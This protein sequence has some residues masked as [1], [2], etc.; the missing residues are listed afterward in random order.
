MLLAPSQSS[1]QGKDAAAM[2]RLGVPGRAS[3][4]AWRVSPVQPD[5]GVFLVTAVHCNHRAPLVRLD[6]Q[7]KPISYLSP[8][9]IAQ[10]QDV[11]LLRYRS[12]TGPGYYTISD[13]LPEYGELIVGVG[14]AT[15]NR[16]GTRSYQ[17]MVIPG[18][19]VGQKF[20]DVTDEIL[21]A[22]M[23]IQ[24]GMSGGAV[25]HKDGMFAIMSFRFPGGMAGISDVRWV[26]ATIKAFKACRSS[27][28]RWNHEKGACN[29]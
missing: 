16:R 1:A 11:L 10:E 9:R 23:P 6:S 20:T 27:K 5:G 21:T 26:P 25:G 3:C 4:S 17:W 2:V 13:R 22:W 29:D 15:I 28:R 12:V 19:Y 18:M 7:G 8:T 14:Y 24:G